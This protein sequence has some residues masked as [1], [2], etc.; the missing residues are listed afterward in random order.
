M[1]SEAIAHGLVE[2]RA[3]AEGNMTSACTV[4]ERG[5]G[6]PVTDPDTGAVTYPAGE[7]VYSGKC[8]IKPG[9]VRSQMTEAGGAE[10][11]SYD[12]EVSLP[13]GA[14]GSADVREGMPLTIDASPDSA[15]V[16]MNVEIQQ[17][18]RGEQLTARRL[19]CN[20]VAE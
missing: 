8:R 4:R 12:L 2:M 17:V 19:M 11:F 1:L 14:P 13:F 9:G 3:E 15:A 20:E 5:T 16:G 18:A 10:M 6:E 7:V